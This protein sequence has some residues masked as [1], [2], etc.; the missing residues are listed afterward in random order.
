MQSFL[1]TGSDEKERIEKFEKIVGEK[2]LSLKKSPDFFILQAVENSIGIAEV[3]T[4]Q[5]KLSLKPYRE[6]NKIVLF[7]EAQNMT[8]EAQNSLLKTLEEPDASTLIYLTAPDGFWLLP[9]ITSR[10][11]I[12]CL[13]NKEGIKIEQKEE[14]EIT[15]LFRILLKST[16]GRRL[17]IIEEEGIA[18]DKTTAVNFLDKLLFIVRK[19]LLKDYETTSFN[20]LSLII[21]Y[22]KYL[23]ANCNVKLTL[24][25]FLI[26]LPSS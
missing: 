10:C 18:K 2:L 5:K 19:Q 3:R 23:E 9:T 6:K 4:L 24:E 12:I 26:E 25:I 21:K 1:I 16:T 8:V 17:K 15:K 13:P 11:Q 14:Q 20:V 7:Y 22:K